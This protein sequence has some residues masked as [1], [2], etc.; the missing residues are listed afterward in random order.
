MDHKIIFVVEFKSFQTSEAK[1]HHHRVLLINLKWTKLTKV[2]K[3][4]SKNNR[5]KVQPKKIQIMI[6]LE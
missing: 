2:S 1:V 6:L 5:L 3:L 4:S